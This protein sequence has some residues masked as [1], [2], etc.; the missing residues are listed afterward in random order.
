MTTSFR[1]SRRSARIR[2]NDMP[3]A[4]RGM[5]PAVM[6]F[7]TLLV[8]AL[9][10]EA[11]A[12]TYTVTNTT[13][14]GAGS[15]RQAIT[16]A[17]LQ[18]V[19]G[20]EACAGHSIV[21]AIPGTGVHTIQPLSALPKFN[22][23]I[24]LDGYTQ[25]GSSVNTLA[26]GT[27]ALITIEL[28]GTLAGATDA[29]VIGASIPNS[30]LCSGSGSV[31]RGLVINRFAGAALSMGEE[32]C[33]VNATCGVGGVRI[34]GNFFGTDVSG[35]LA[36]P[37]GV[38]LGR[39]NL[40]FA[41]G[42]ANN[43]VGD[44]SADQGGPT[45]P[46]PQTRNLISAS[47][48]D[49]ISIGSP[50]ADA[51]SAGHRIRNNIIG[52]SASGTS[53]L[54]NAGR[55][56][57]VGLNSSNIAIH[58]NLISANLDDGVAI[59]DSPTAGTSLIAN[60]IGVGVGGLPFGNAGHG[61]VIAGNSNGV[62]VARRYL[63]S[64]FGAS[65]I[66]NNA[67]AGLFINDLAQV[68]VINA[69]ISGNGGLAIDLAPL[70]ATPN[71]SGDTDSGPNETLNKP[72]LQSAITDP[73]TLETTITGGLSAAPNSSYEIHFYL[74]SSCD[75]G[76]FGGGQSFFPLFPPPTIVSVTTNATG[77]AA[78]VRQIA[79]LGSGMILTALT[80][81][82]ATAPGVPALIVSEFSNCVVAVSSNDL[83]F[84]N[85]FEP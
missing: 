19:T 36:R 13:D 61:V 30:S 85:G 60:A 76:G 83:I 74:S 11:L 41:S 57:T 35:M 58:D 59:F 33:P 17:N 9:A 68:D 45:D 21:F 49:G 3:F 46:M 23:P 39:A 29:I 75:A 81:R 62:L 70:G 78:F 72:V 1:K 12:N 25:P 4:H 51:P 40:V 44:Q 42:S 79:G 84:R 14:S 80:R 15:L 16:D 56:I 2:I 63:Y 67:G 43:I 20:G 82:F 7:A 22:I 54:P 18:Q 26:Q 47:G 53:A 65:S 10:G 71:D 66:S 38:I 69:S 73:V 77:D 64:A 48:G 52:L 6:R 24:T 31:I 8:F 50:R 37:N 32:A 27:N 34:Q 28:D 5:Q 55:G